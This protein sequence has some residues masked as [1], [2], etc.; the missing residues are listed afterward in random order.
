MIIV[1]VSKQGKTGVVSRGS[2]PVT[3]TAASSEVRALSKEVIA[4]ELSF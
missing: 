3:V 4:F 2:S 1:S